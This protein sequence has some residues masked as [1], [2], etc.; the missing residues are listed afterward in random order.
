MPTQPISAVAAREV[1]HLLIL[2]TL[3]GIGG[4][5]AVVVKGGVNLRLF[6]GSVRYSEDIDLDGE[7]DASQAIRSAIKGI[8]SDRAFFRVLQR[9][10]I[11]GLDPGEG[12]NKDTETTFRYKFNVIL[13]GD[14]RH[15]TKVEV[16]FR[17]RF[18][19]DL[20]V[21]EVPDERVLSPCHVEP[22]AVRHYVRD[23]AVR[24]K[25]SALGGRREA[26]ARDVFDLHVLVGRYQNRYASEPTL[27]FLAESLEQDGLMKAHKRA[28]DITYE[29]FKGQVVEFLAEDARSRYG[30]EGAWDELRLEAATLVE[31][32]LKRK[33]AP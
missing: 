25:I 28:L 5:D 20:S 3:A 33:C 27:T 29:E 7:A 18:A 6:F 2:R 17:D 11:R 21:V 22:L 15:P 16:S 9:I 12:P 31:E 1:V 8:F 24:Q 14:V 10:G 30:A 19:G 4:G 32:V 13:P 23:A 26:Q